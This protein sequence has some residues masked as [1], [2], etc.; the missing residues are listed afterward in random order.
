MNASYSISLSR[1]E[2]LPQL[3][4]ID[5]TAGDLLRGY[6]SESLLSEQMPLSSF[7]KA[8]EKNQLWVA[9]VAGPDDISGSHCHP[10]GFAMI[11]VFDQH[12][13]HLAEISVDPTYGRL[14][15]GT[16]LVRRVLNWAASQNFKKM[17]LTTFRDVAWNHPFYEK[18]GFCVLSDGEIMGHLRNIV[19]SERA[20]GLDS[21]SPRVA[22]EYVVNVE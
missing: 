21:L 4:S 20:R 7:Q 5:D 16:A 12:H 15:I 3:I 9:R 19:D 13:A 11:E 10:V 22:M 18:L 6:I 1:V 14:G 2:D 8:H 17:T